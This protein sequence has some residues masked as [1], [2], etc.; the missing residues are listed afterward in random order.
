LVQAENLGTEKN[1]FFAVQINK[2]SKELYTLLENLLQW[3][4]KQSGNLKFQPEMFNINNVIDDVFSL[5]DIIAREKNILLSKVNCDKEVFADKNMIETVFRNILS[6]A[7]KFTPEN[8]NI[9]IHTKEENNYLYISISDNGTGI[10]PE[11]MDFI[12]DYS[13]TYSSSD[14]KEKGSGI[15]LALCRDFVKINGG[16]IYVQS[17]VNVGTTFTFSIPLKPKK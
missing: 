10:P 12:F 1:K 17:E 6:N 4:R 8:G 5:Y 15:G 16:S 2:S 11:K 13:Y 14:M 7:L 3:S 9:N